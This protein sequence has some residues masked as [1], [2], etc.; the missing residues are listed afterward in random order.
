MT[1]LALLCPLNPDSGSTGH[2]SRSR[3]LPSCF[4]G[5]RPQ[6]GC[7]VLGGGPLVPKTCHSTAFLKDSVG[8]AVT[9]ITSPAAF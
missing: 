1:A 5:L 2:L 4:W 6:S 9:S 7:A 3:S 8:E